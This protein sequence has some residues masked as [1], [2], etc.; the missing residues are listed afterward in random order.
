M[1]RTELILFGPLPA[2]LQFVIYG[3]I[4]WEYKIASTLNNFD[5]IFDP[6]TCSEGHIV[7]SSYFHIRNLTRLRT[8]LFQHHLWVFQREGWNTMIQFAGFSYLF[9]VHTSAV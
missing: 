3:T 6:E 8:L 5:V 9:V 4:C 7:K 2:K 1:L